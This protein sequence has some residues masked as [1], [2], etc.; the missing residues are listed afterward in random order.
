M[1]LQDVNSD[2]LDLKCRN[3]LIEFIHF[4]RTPLASIKIG[5]EILKDILPVLL[6]AYNNSSLQISNNDVVISDDKLN[7]LHSIIDNIVIEANRISE[8]TQKIE[9]SG[10]KQK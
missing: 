4:I 9:I 8:Y 10:L 7:K 1:M 3:E 6:S 5:G 2:C